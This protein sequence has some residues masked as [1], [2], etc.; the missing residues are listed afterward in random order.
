MDDLAY[1]KRV[2]GREFRVLAFTV[3]S[4]TDLVWQTLRLRK[5][6]FVDGLGWPLAVRDGAERDQFD[7]RDTVY[8]AVVEAGAPV[9]CWRMLP[10]TG[11]Y[12]L[13]E[14][15]PHLAGGHPL[16]RS[17]RAWEISRFGADPAHPAP[18]ACTKELL[19]LMLALARQRGIETVCA[20]TDEAFERVLRR[21]GLRLFRY[22]TGPGPGE[23]GALVAGGLH[24]AEQAPPR[25][26]QARQAGR[27]LGEAA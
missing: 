22:G 12:L 8:G 7:R 1:T 26:P 20:V 11:P 24:V 5:R 16:P 9:A 13:A 19:A 18:D 27:D 17:P 23:R 15:F 2:A 4:H 21:A 6:I 25:A 14:V 3:G 10:T